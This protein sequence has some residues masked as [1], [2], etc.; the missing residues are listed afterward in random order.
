MKYEHFLDGMFKFEIQNSISAL[1]PV[2][3][4]LRSADIHKLKKTIENARLPDENL[5]KNFLAFLEILTVIDFVNT[6]NHHKIKNIPEA[7]IDRAIQILSVEKFERGFDFSKI[8]DLLKNVQIMKQNPL[9]DDTI[10]SHDHSIAI[11]YF[12]Y[13]LFCNVKARREYVEFFKMINSKSGLIFHV[14]HEILNGI[15]KIW[16]NENFSIV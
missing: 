15:I 6:L 13:Y 11:N 5:K 2:D 16:H 8:I 12:L 7:T 4:F 9:K 1:T 3:S 10:I 14:S